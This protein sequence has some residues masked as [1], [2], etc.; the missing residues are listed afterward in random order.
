MRFGYDSRTA[1]DSKEE[2]WSKLGVR[3]ELIA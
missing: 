3:M 1:P 2:T